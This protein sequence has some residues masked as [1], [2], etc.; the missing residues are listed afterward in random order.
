M[1]QKIVLGTVQ[2]GL[3]YGINNTTGKPT[4][5]DA[6]RILDF[7]FENK[8]R[9]VDT[10]DGYGEALSV[11][12]RHKEQTGISF[13]VVNKFKITSESLMSTLQR[14]LKLLNTSSLYCYMY[15][16]FS[17]CLTPKGRTELIEMKN[18]GYIEKQAFLCTV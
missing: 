3:A 14:S 1:K 12:G 10:A 15:H 16:Q 7:A 9:M 6:F 17:D 11:I 5:K 8:I 4:E 13:K 2:L 18:R